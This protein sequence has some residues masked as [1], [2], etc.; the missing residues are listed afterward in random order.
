M[1]VQN[2]EIWGRSSIGRALALQAR[3][4]RFDPGR[5]HASTGIKKLEEYAGRVRTD[6]TTGRTN[7]GPAGRTGRAGRIRGP[8]KTF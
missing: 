2:S 7:E 6:R 1:K 5:L 8:K 3:G 4:C